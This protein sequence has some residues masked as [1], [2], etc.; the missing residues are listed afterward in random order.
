M[1]RLGSLKLRLPSCFYV[2]ADPPDETGNE[3]LHVISERRRI[4]LKGH[5][6]REFHRSVV[7]LLDGTH[8][9]AEIEAEL[10]DVFEAADLEAALEL[11]VQHG[12]LEDVMQQSEPKSAVRLEPQLNFF[13]EVAPDGIAAQRRLEQATIAVLGLGG[14]GAVAARALAGAGVGRV[15]CI[16]HLPVAETDVYLSSS[17]SSGDIGKSRASVLACHIS[18]GDGP[19]RVETNE[20]VLETDADVEQAVAGADFAICAADAAQATLFYRLNRVSLQTGLKWIACR[21]SALE[22]V[23]GPTVHPGE[24]ACYMCYRMRSV[25]CADEPGEELAFQRF[26][27]RRKCDDAGRR[28]NLCFAAGITG[29]LLAL[30]VFKALTGVGSLATRG[31]IVVFNP[32]EMLMEK[33]VVLRKPWCPACLAPV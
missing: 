16:D 26:L 33:H 21:S 19:G 20:D 17:Y 11:L 25:A 18:A 6:F 2:L 1:S 14:P 7:P 10:A 4:K 31:R 27:D 5:A 3:T 9:V 28:E 24:T 13:R 30:E 22:V 23:V 15:I 8:T 29:N 32:L 12:I